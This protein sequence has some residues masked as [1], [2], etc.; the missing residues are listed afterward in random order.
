MIYIIQI[1][2]NKS[3]EIILLASIVISILLEIWPIKSTGSFFSTWNATFFW[4][5][6]SMLLANKTEKLVK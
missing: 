1:N 3:V 6:I 4:L 5:F 2:K